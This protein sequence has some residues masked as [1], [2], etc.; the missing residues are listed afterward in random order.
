M[1]STEITLDPDQQKIL[2]TMATMEKPAGNKQIAEAA[3]VD[4]KTMAKKMKGLKDNGL[5]HSP[6]R[7][8]Y[9]ISDE[10]KECL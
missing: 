7:C 4:A 5:I 6:I 2:A 10:G 1:S 8:K 3:G 9:S